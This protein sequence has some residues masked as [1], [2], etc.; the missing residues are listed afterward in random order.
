MPT[1]GTASQTKLE[2]ISTVGVVNF[3][4]NS[5][6]FNSNDN[7]HISSNSKGYAVL[8][9]NNTGTGYTYT[10]PATS[11]TIALTSQIPT[12]SGVYLPLAGGTMTG[13]LNGTAASFTNADY[14]QITYTNS[15]TS[16]DLQIGAGSS[17]ANLFSKGGFDFRANYPTNTS[18]NLFISS[19][20]NVGINTTSISFGA[21]T[22]LAI[23]SATRSNLSLTD[24]TNALN[25]F[26]D[27]TSAYFNMYS[28][29]DIIFRNT[30]GN[31]ERLRLTNAGKVGIG[32]SSPVT[33]LDVYADL[34]GWG[35]T[36][37]NA[38]SSSVQTFL[39][40]GGGYGIAV[41]S[42]ANTS[43]VYLLKLASGNGT[44][45]GTN[46]RFQVN[47]DGNVGIGTSSPA[48]KLE[49]QD[50][51]LNIY[52]DNGAN[53]AG[54]ALQF[55][56]NGGGAKN[57]V[58]Y[59]GVFNVGSARSAHMVFQTANG[60]APIDRMI[61]NSAGG[62]QIKNID[63]SN[64]GVHVQSPNSY[65]SNG[66]THSCLST[67]SVSFYHFVGQSGN[68]SS[69]TTNDIL[70]YGNGNVVNANNSYG[71]ISDI[72][73]KENIIDATPKLDDL[74]KVKI[75]NYNLIG[76]QAKQIGVIAQE[77][78][79]I[80]PSMIEVGKDDFKNVKYS[81]FVPMLIK[82]M[83]EQQAQIEDLKA[84]IK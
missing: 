16:N 25:I 81:I 68:G 32:I 59:I 80:F 45:R 11:G 48:S 62:V 28:S 40:H 74:L 64:V 66:F 42:A 56:T 18:T 37:Y 54:Y 35:A 33:K 13:T 49:V 63:V 1:A 72:K 43:G 22:G 2:N 60:A 44:D 8:A 82:A 4:A 10:L 67:A 52:H 78:E 76:N 29:G 26:Q 61:I 55:L 58:G 50:G 3:G 65:N 9:F 75:R 38:F 12:V 57:S 30:T 53:G 19:A 51:Y 77:L 41:D 84:K 39:S 31:T 24:G 70:I 6:G 15:S 47:A 69:V 17:N 7:L 14:A 21:G 73:L 36:F 23:S 79:E 27:G 83:Q 20:G 34:S 71:A 5:L 46:V